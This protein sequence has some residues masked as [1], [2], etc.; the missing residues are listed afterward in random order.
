[1]AQDP[2]IGKIAGKC[3]IIERIGEGGTAFVYRAHNEAFSMERV[4]KVLKRELARDMDFFPKFQQEAQLVARLD[5]PNILRVFDTGI[6]EDHFYIEMEFIK[7]MTLR[8]F[9]QRHHRIPEKTVLDIALQIAKALHY[10]HDTELTTP[11][12]LKVRGILHLDLKPE[13]IMI[14]PAMEVKLMDFGAAKMLIGPGPTAAGERIFGTPSYMSPEQV[15]GLPLD[16]K[17]D[18]FS[19]GT[20]IY[21]MLTN[22]KAFPGETAEA[23][24]MLVRDSKREPVRKYR[25]AVSPWTE[26]Q[27]D[28]LLAVKPSHRPHT[29]AEIENDLNVCTQLYKVWGTGARMTVPFSIRKHFPV[30]AMILASAAFVL[31]SASFLRTCNGSPIAYDAPLSVEAQATIDKGLALERAGD[32]RKA[33]AE[34]QQ[35]PEGAREYTQA[36]VRAA[37][38]LF[39]RLQ[40]LSNA[41]AI[42]ENLKKTDEDPYVDMILGQIYYQLAQYPEARDRIVQSLGSSRDPVLPISD[43]DKEE[44]HY[45]LAWCWDKEYQMLGKDQTALEEAIKAWSYYI[46]SSCASAKTKR[47]TTASNHKEALKAELP[48]N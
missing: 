43:D 48:K 19:F 17:S 5:H 45:F 39:K 7:G 44:M 30:L 47:C 14:T 29:A 37:L 36:Q 26:E 38:I 22:R 9:Q 3:R 35:V 10:A 18:F 8:E 27:V 11:D 41:R 40:Q 13:N 32:F 24:M 46:E 28:K 21:E 34:Y 31:A 12:G 2:F 42:L 1:M 6:F 23:I 25:R 4:V 15:A 16:V 33:I 20:I